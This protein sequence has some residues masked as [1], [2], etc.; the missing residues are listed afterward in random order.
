MEGAPAGKQ[1]KHRQAVKAMDADA[2][3]ATWK[4][5]LQL[6]QGMQTLVQGKLADVNMR[7]M[8]EMREDGKSAAQ[9]F[10]RYVR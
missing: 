7:L 2:T 3:A 1:A 8:R 6:K 10:W 9:K 4:R 5:Y